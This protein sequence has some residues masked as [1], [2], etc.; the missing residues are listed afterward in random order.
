[1]EQSLN[2]IG[3]SGEQEAAEK[4]ASP[5]EQGLIEKLRQDEKKEASCAVQRSGELAATLLDQS[6]GGQERNR[7]NHGG[8]A[9][10][11]KKGIVTEALGL[12]KKGRKNEDRSSV[13]ESKMQ[14]LSLLVQKIVQNSCWWERHGID[15]TIIML[16]FIS[17]PAGFLLLKSDC[18]LCFLAGFI[19]L[20]MSHTVITVKGSHLASHS[21]L[22]ESKLWSKF[23]A[24]F[25]IEVCGAFTAEKGTHAHVKMHHA[26]TNV[27]GLG[28]SS[29]WKI[30]FLPR[31]VYMF[32]APLAV[33]IITPVVALGLLLDLPPVI[34]IRTAC[35]IALGLWSQYWLL[36]NVSGFQSTSSALLCMFLYRAIFS[37]PYIH[38]NIFQH[39]GLP[40][41]A[42]DKKPKRIY[43]MSH[44]VLNLPRNVLL[45]WFFG[46]SLINCHVEH[47]LFPN[48][49]DHMCLKV[50]P[51]VSRYLKQQHL[52]YNEDTYISRL[53]LFI[54]KYEEL[55][56][57]APPIT[58]L[59]GIQ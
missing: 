37:I 31:Y 15:C 24:I 13:Q 51:I 55:M 1:M 48:L 33:P 27:I 28:D 53:K 30:P 34:A 47:H 12:A 44:G 54:Q 16:G 29:M 56:V 43:Q 45:D 35:M 22:T 17:L 21:A 6:C 42:I 32:I 26:Y 49:S 39:I 50:K 2:D 11:S 25:I 9:H 38:V 7:K 58:E 14:E 4:P 3:K 46:H 57:H 52:P 20:G 23:L 5:E 18:A 41:F 40:M 19:L 36:M 59:V 10:L 8:Q